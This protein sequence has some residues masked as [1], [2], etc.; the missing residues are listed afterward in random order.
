MSPGSSRSPRASARTSNTPVA[1]AIV[2][3][4][5]AVA[6]NAATYFTLYPSDAQAPKPRASDLNPSAGQVI[7]N[8]GDRAARD[9]T[10]NGER[11]PLQR[12][13]IINAILDVAGW[14][15]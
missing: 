10:N 6:G 5:T 8:L 2:A 12:G 7:A 9:P 3:N 13:G 15:Q 11:E 4:L 1:V 14:F